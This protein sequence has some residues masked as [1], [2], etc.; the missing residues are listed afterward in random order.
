MTI[1]LKGK[2][3]PLAGIAL[4]LVYEVFIRLWVVLADQ[5]DRFAC[6]AYGKTSSLGRSLRNRG[7]GRRFPERFQSGLHSF[8]HLGGFVFLVPQSDGS[9]DPDG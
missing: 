3:R 1:P 8:L 4:H 5:T 6:E 2:R 7:R 9:D